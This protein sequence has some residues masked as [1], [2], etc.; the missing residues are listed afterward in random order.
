[1]FATIDP[2][3]SYWCNA[4]VVLILMPIADT[5]FIVGNLF[6]ISTMYAKSQALAGGLF[7]TVIRVR[8]PPPT[9]KA[10]QHVQ[11]LSTAI[12]LAVTS[13]ITATVTVNKSRDSL[14]SPDTLLEGYHVAG[15]ICFS[16]ALIGLPIELLLPTRSRGYWRHGWHVRKRE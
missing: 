5:I 3:V 12:D 1:M 8:A 10:H 13:A 15:W 14:P 4:F 6:T 11:Q 2:T 16:M 9:T 7:S